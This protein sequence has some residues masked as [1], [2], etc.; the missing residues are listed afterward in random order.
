MFLGWDPSFK[1]SLF[2]FIQERDT[3]FKTYGNFQLIRIAR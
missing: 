1:E 3:T 2:Q